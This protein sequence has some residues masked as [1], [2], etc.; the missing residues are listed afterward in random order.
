MNGINLVG[1]LTKDPEIKYA[2]TGKA[3]CKITLAVKKAGSEGANFIN[4]VAFDKT[5][6]TIA[7]YVAKGRELAVTGSLENQKPYEKEGK[8]VYPENIVVI[9][10]FTFLGSGKNENKQKD[11][12]DE[13]DGEFEG[14]F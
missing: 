8:K 11:L 12:H 10:G 9:R 5:A 3:V 2:Q 13:F 6:E 4:C 14:D 1:R 7:N